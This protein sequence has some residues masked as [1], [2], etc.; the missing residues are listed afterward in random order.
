MRT[1][2]TLKFISAFFAFLLI[3]FSG[4]RVFAQLK[5]PDVVKLSQPKTPTSEGYR[6][7]WGVD[8]MVNNFGFGV[9]GTYS[10]VVGPY[11]Q[12]TFRTGMTGI[13]NDAE[14][15]YQSFITGQQIIP[16][17]YK[18]A[19]GFPFLFGVKHRLFPRKIA[20]NFRPFISGSAGPA[21]AFT[22]PYLDD[23]NHN[24]FRDFNVVSTPYGPTLTPVERIND[25]F[26]GWKNGHSHWGLSGSIKIGADI[27]SFKHPFTVEF[28]YFFYYFKPGLQIMEP[29]KPSGYDKSGLP[30]NPVPFYDAQSYFGTPQIRLTFGGMW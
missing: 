13:R 1:L 22:Y 2:K 23:N 8:I 17:K 3:G 25:F 27:G 4:S 5:E 11:T 18:R 21:M 19:W 15:N 24:G 28:G 20:D 30:V 10:H 12:L 6:N 29:Y 14:Q 16:N 26:T 7:S 9:G